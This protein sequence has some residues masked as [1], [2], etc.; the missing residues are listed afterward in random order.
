[1]VKG[2][3]A[4]GGASVEET[5]DLQDHTLWHML[6]LEGADRRELTSLL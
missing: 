2:F 5:H 1:M 4:E 3:L 6:K